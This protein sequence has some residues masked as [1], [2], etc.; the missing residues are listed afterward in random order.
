MDR[1]AAVLAAADRLID[2]FRSNDR[3]KYFGAFA[4]EANFVFHSYPR[5]MD[6]RAEYLAVWEGWIADDQFQVHTCESTDRSVMLFDRTAIFTHTVTTTLS[7]Q[8]EPHRWDERETIVFREDDAHGWLAVH[9]H[10]SARPV[11][12]Q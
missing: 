2:G 1:T 8:G 5:R 12:P 11:E 7:I 6:S 3:A 9:E 4:P 10:L